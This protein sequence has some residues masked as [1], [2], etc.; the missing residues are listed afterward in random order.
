MSTPLHESAIFKKNLHKIGLS[1]FFIVDN[2]ILMYNSLKIQP[3]SLYKH[4]HSEFLWMTLNSIYSHT[5]LL[6]L[7]TAEI[8][9]LSVLVF[10]D[11]AGW[12]PAKDIW[13]VKMLQISN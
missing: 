12:T 13:L 9:I 5:R 2:Y 4:I 3:R 7:S 10:F 1:L 11:T 6:T 8:H